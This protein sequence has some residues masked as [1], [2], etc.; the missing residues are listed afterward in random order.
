MKK[1]LFIAGIPHSGT[2][3]LDK[4]LDLHDEISSIV[5]YNKEPVDLIENDLNIFLSQ[6]R[7]NE[8]INKFNTKDNQYLLMK[9]P[10]NLDFL[11]QILSMKHKVIIIYRDL[12]DVAL[13]LVYRN[14]PFW[15]DYESAI[16]YCVERYKIIEN[17]DS[18][19]LKINYNDLIN[20]FEIV[21]NRI[22]EYLDIP[23]N[24]IMKRY[25]NNIDEKEIPGDKHHEDRRRTQ[26]KK[27]LYN[28]SRFEKE[29]TKEQKILYNKYV[30]NV[31]SLKETL[32]V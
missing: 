6:N 13:S 19:I 10:D 9:N 5:D 17:C 8:Y 29:T 1:I 32:F 31:E 23:Y 16:K 20:N 12:R 26:L 3:L 18:N 28:S 2:S 21:M 22:N 7:F 14:D 4:L 25:E 30:K 27:K 15:P 11:E 24:D